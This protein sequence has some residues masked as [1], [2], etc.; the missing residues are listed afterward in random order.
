MLIR[1]DVSILRKL[2]PPQ[3]DT[4]GHSITWGRVGDGHIYQH[5]LYIT[6]ALNT[7]EPRVCFVYWDTPACHDQNHIEYID[8]YCFSLCNLC[9]MAAVSTLPLNCPKK[10]GKLKWKEKMKPYKDDAIF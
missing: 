9:D 5:Q 2:C 7:Y 10:F 8:E 1:V 6:D 4:T 3:E